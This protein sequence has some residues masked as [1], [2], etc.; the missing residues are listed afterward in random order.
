MAEQ[1]EEYD[2]NYIQALAEGV[3][4]YGLNLDDANELKAKYDARFQLKMKSKRCCNCRYW[5]HVVGAI[6]STSSHYCRY[7]QVKLNVSEIHDKT[8]C[9]DYKQCT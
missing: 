5:F 2:W 1:Q 9:E 8:D 3:L 4:H 7:K 6:F